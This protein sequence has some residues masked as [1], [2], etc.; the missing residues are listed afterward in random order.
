MALK[1]LDQQQALVDFLQITPEG[2]TYPVPHQP[3]DT[4]THEK[5][6][7]SLTWVTLTSRWDNCNSPICLYLHNTIKL[8]NLP[9]LSLYS[10][11]CTLALLSEWRIHCKVLNIWPGKRGISFQLQTLAEIFITTASKYH[12]S[13]QVHFVVVYKSVGEDSNTHWINTSLI[14]HRNSS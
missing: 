1:L 9:L 4:A 5:T 2:V 3:N 13:A 7:R 12:F 11:T 10:C 14:S 8:C 6:A